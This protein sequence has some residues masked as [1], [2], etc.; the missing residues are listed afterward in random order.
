MNLI[1][2]F[3]SGGPQPPRFHQSLL[4]RRSRSVKSLS[5]KPRKSSFSFPTAGRRTAVRLYF[6]AS[7]WNATAAS[8]AVGVRTGGAD[9]F[10]ISERPANDDFS[11]ATVIEGERGSRPVDLL[12]ATPEPGEPLFTPLAGSGPPVRSGTPG[13]HRRMVRSVSTPPR[14]RIPRTCANDR[15]DIFQ[16]DRISALE[17]I[18][19]DLWGTIFFAEKGQS[20]RI[21]VSNFARGAALNL[22]W[23]QGSR[24][25]NDDFAQATVLEGAGGVVEGS[26]QGATLEPGEWFG[27]VAATTWYRWTA[28]SDGQWTFSSEDPRRVLVFEGDSMPALRLVSGF[29]GSNGSFPGWRREGVSHRCRRAP[30]LC[31]QR[32]V[33]TEMESVGD[34]AWPL[35]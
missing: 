16:G 7:A 1:L 5:V 33:R 22:R 14:A 27:R 13:Q 29:P 26:S 4:V 24:P 32:S 15:L 20:Y 10:E 6:T 11:A 9:Q 31:V 23:S 30:C 34:S 21:R 8:V 17:Q 12:L 28:P 2:W 35:Q 18:A 25:A 3:L 19:S